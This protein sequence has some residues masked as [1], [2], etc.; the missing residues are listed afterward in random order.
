MD[1]EIINQLDIP[2]GLKDLLINRGFTIE[3]LVNMKSND[4]ARDLNIDE[5]VA[6]LIGVAV[7]KYVEERQRK[8]G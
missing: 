1:R 5:D 7:K 8:P 2:T 3:Q 6:R 4:I